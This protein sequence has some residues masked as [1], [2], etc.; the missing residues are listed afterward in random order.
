M[1]AVTTGSPVASESALV[2]AGAVVGINA[3]T[4]VTEGLHLNGDLIDR[5]SRHL[6]LNGSQPL[7]GAMLFERCW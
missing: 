3:I 1:V 7:V 2:A 4:A 5:I 6:R